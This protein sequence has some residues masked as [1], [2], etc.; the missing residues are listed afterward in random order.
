MFQQHDISLAK[1]IR[2]FGRSDFE[3]RAEML[4]ALNN[5][6]FVPV[7]GLGQHDRQLRRDGADWHEHGARHA[8][9]VPRQLVRKQC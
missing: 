4:N 3:F 5:V 8:V 9:R 7:G 1:R 2:I 6:N